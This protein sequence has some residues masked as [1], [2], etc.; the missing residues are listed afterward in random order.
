MRRLFAAILVLNLP[1]AGAVLPALHSATLKN[2]NCARGTQNVSF[3]E[4]AIGLKEL[5]QPG[6]LA[7]TTARFYYWREKNKLAACSTGFISDQ[8]H[9]LTASHCLQNCTLEGVRRE[10]NVDTGEVSCLTYMAGK[11]VKVKV[12]SSSKCD[13]LDRWQKVG[14]T[15]S[16]GLPLST[17][18]SCDTDDLALVLPETPPENFFCA[19]I[20]G[21][22]PALNE[23]VYAM[24]APGA[25]QRWDGKDSDGMHMYVSNGNV[26]DTDF[27]RR[28]D[29]NTGKPGVPRRLR[30]AEYAR[31]VGYLQVTADSYSGGS[32]G[33]LFNMQGEIIGLSAAFDKFHHNETAECPGATLFQPATKWR[34]I[35]KARDPNVD[36]SQVKCERKRRSP[37]KSD[38]LQP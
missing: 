22:A 27:C 18:A 2:P 28:K 14:N 15:I 17:L 6:E 31:K 19:P 3:T 34:E 10:I 29:R 24:G 23:K 1:T 21:R 33:P 12:I 11:Y 5:M 9:M 4:A 26:V 16:L 20:S 25:T 38:Y 32:G 36:L 8:G 13:I 35:I 7:A 30:F 37:V